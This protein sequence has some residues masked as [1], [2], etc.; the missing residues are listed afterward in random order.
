MT[1]LN[2]S[3]GQRPKDVEHYD[4]RFLRPPLASAKTLTLINAWAIDT[5]PP[6]KSPTMSPQ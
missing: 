4:I 1:S 3:D 5:V 2:P 6:K